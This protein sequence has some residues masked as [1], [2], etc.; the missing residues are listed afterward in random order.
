MAD[1]LKAEL[2][3]IFKTHGETKKK[4]EVERSE[5]EQREE[6]FVQSFY[7]LEESTIRPAFEVIGEYVKGR[8]YEY[9][10]DGKKEGTDRDGRYEAPRLSIRFLLA[11][12]PGHHQEH[13]YPH[14]SVICEKSG[15]KVRFHESTMSPGRG[16]RSGG[17][18]ETGLNEVTAQLLHEKL[19]NLLREVFK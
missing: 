17:V 3:A 16:G 12:R 13:D 1:K 15:D 18:G 7:A 14:F 10:I 5:R 11:D 19:L 9:R 8:G 6:A 4:I 2:D